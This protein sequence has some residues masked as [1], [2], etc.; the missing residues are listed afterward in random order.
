MDELFMLVQLEH[1]ETVFSHQRM[2]E[3]HGGVAGSQQ[4]G[5]ALQLLDGSDKLTRRW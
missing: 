5:N 4:T 1:L 3:F 2:R